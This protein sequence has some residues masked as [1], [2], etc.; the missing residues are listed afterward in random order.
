VLLVH[1]EEPEALVL[2]EVSEQPVLRE[3]PDLLVQGKQVRQDLVGKLEEPAALE[4]REL[5]ERPVLR[6]FPAG[7]SLQ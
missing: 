3:L 6:V 5:L 1:L 2:Q 7:P 4:R